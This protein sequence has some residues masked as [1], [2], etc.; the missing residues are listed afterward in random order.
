[1]LVASSTLH[2]HWP[3]LKF[4]NPKKNLLVCFSTSCSSISNILIY[5]ICHRN[6]QTRASY[7]SNYLLKEWIIKSNTYA[8]EA[9][10]RHNQPAL[11]QSYSHLVKQYK[12]TKTIQASPK[13]V[14]INLFTP[15]IP[16]KRSWILLMVLQAVEES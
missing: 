7:D 10:I 12:I 3:N 16:L 6:I 5:K 9:L 4:S 2:I 14:M 13:K 11:N 15:K 1:M 8:I